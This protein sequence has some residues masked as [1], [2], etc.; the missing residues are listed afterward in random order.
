MT[1]TDPDLKAAIAVTRFGLGARPGDLDAARGDPQGWLAAQI[2]PAGADLPQAPGGGALPS[3][4]QRYRDF[5]AYRAAVKA[6]GTDM[7]ARKSASQ[8]LNDQTN[9]ETLSR[10][11]LGAT[12]PSPFRERWALFW[13]NHFTVSSA[14]G[15]DVAATAAAFEREAIR[16]HVF[17]RFHDLLAAASGHPVML[18]YLD[19][20]QSVGP[21]SPAGRKR[22]TSGLNENLGREIMELHALGVDAGYT[23]ADVTEFARALTGWSMAGGGSPPEQQG[24][25]LYKPN[26]HEPGPR[27][28]FGKTY[29]PGEQAQA[30][31]V[32]AD[33][34]AS[35]HTAEHVARRIG[36]HFVADTPPPALVARLK[37]AY[38]DSHG[39]LSAVATTLITAPDAWALAAQKLKTPYEFVLSAYRAT[40]TGPTDVRRDVLNPLGAMGH[41]PFAAP[42]PN[43]WSDAL[44]DWAAPDAIIKRLTWSKTFANANA[45]LGDPA[46]TAQAT[47]GARLSPLTL[48]TVKRAETGQEAFA[49]LLMS[50]EFQRR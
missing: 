24:L 45:P 34:A 35:P 36:A 38:L 8:A 43:G 33:F 9:Q 19:Q 3:A 20:V 17:G 1:R 21:G 41:R 6:A 40:G 39:D 27:Q 23:Q 31:A 49:I 26:V 50:P 28:V 29:A 47:L 42:Q 44:A 4:Q 48:T 13:G 25:F 32:L 5:L 10:A 37:R 16:P 22:A 46:M 7:V 11:W 2:S 18:T 12:T 15:E 30:Q 14:K